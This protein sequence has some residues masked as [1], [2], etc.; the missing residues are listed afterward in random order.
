[1]VKW[2]MATVLFLVAVG[3]LVGCGN[4]E[5][6]MQRD[7]ATFP[8]AIEVFENGCTTCHGDNLQGGIGPNLQHVGS[9]LSKA[10]IAHR[11]EVG[12]G[13]MPAYT[14]PGD[15]I[16]TQSQVDAVATWLAQQK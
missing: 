16:L 2:G 11:I 6:V 10:A 7:A 9:R 14:A 15:A 12:S 3:G 4:R 13:P 8:I 1:M 5:T